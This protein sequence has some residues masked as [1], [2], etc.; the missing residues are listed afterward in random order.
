MLSSV[1]KLLL[2]KACLVTRGN[3]RTLVCRF[4]KPYCVSDGHKCF[5]LRLV[6]T[7]LERTLSPS[8]PLENVGLFRLNI[9]S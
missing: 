1:R 6:R 8:P 4:M 3:I 7:F 2:E 9:D 5:G